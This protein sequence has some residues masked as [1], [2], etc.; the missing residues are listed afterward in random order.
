MENKFIQLSQK[1]LIA[2]KVMKEYEE[3]NS[4]E[5]SKIVLEKVGILLNLIDSLHKEKVQ[6]PSWQIWS[7]ALIHKLS[8]H[9]VT[10]L[11]LFEGT[12]IPYEDHGKNVIVLDKPS[13]ITLLRVVTENYLTFNYLYGSSITND[14]KQFRLSVWRYC[15]IKQRIEFDITTEDAKKKQE[16][17]VETLNE[18]KKE[19]IDSPFYTVFTRKQQATIIDGKKPRLFNSW[20]KLIEDSGL[21]VQLFKNMYGYKSN[22]SHSEFISVLQV[23][24]RNYIFRENAEIEIELMLLNI[25]ICKSIINLK[26]TFSTIKAN[27]DNLN[28]KAIDEIEFINKFGSEDFL[29]I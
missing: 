12:I 17:E 22:Y 10:L 28:S 9:A 18:L 3:M 27:Y 4:I 16:K 26:D 13:I 24:D 20:I 25:I 7:E 19:V 5:Y 29:V 6:V 21:R 14:E 23:H 8:F 1:D 2:I 15:G 11:K